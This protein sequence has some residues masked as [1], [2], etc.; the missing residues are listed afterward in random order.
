MD[1]WCE[2]VTPEGHVYWFNRK[3]E[4][5]S[6]DPPAG[7]KSTSGN[8]RFSPGPLICTLLC[9]RHKDVTIL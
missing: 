8:V 1:E 6:W 2:C 9:G 5:S 3:T 4:E 7:I